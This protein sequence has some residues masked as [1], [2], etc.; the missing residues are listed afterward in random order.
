MELCYRI[1]LLGYDIMYYPYFVVSHKAQGSSS[2]AFA[3]EQI[4]KGFLYLYKKHNNFLNYQLLRMMLYIKAY[5]AITVGLI[6]NNN[7]LLET[8][9]KAKRVI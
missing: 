5:G 7:D 8:Y 1:K 9:R 6:T 4:Y 3:I 2:R